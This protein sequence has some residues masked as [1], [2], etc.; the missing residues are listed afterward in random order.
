M[1]DAE[2]NGKALK[3]KTPKMSSS[4]YLP[5]KHTTSPQRRY[6]VAATP[7]A[8]TPRRCSDVVTTL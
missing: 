4:N 1:G 8:T 2:G 3:Q 5:S 7:V 6:K